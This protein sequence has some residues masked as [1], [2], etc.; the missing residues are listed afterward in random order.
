M[1]DATPQDATGANTHRRLAAH[2]FN[3]VWTLMEKPDCTQA[4]NDT[5]L[6][7]AHASRY[8][9][10]QVGTTVNLAWGGWQ[11]SRVYAT[12]RR[13]EPAGFHAQR[14]LEICPWATSRL[15]PRW[16]RSRQSESGLH[17]TLGGGAC[18]T[19]AATA[20]PEG[21]PSPAS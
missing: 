1:T 21:Q 12:L 10:E 19:Q 20:H 8:H 18:A 9:W 3:L 4:E 2:L 11:V 6:H 15:S 14:C 16:T 13:V 5:M 7:A 17:D